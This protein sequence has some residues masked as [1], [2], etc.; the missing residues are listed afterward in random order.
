MM[1]DPVLHSQSQEGFIMSNQQ[2]PNDSTNKSQSGAKSVANDHQKGSDAGRKGGQQSHAAGSGSTT[3]D[4]G[5]PRGDADKGKNAG[6]KDDSHSHD[7][8]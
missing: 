4:P 8:R 5:K 7:E 1:M 3:G 2:H 6:K